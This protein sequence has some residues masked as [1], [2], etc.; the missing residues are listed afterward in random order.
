MPDKSY[1]DV[2]VPDSQFATMPRLRTLTY[3][4]IP[5]VPALA[6]ER[7]CLQWPP[8]G[9]ALLVGNVNLSGQRKP[10]QQQAHYDRNQP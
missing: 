4:P 2:G 8:H 1:R 5:S 7:P 9:T 3:A 10:R 6:S